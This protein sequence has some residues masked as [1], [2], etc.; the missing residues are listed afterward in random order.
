MKINTTKRNFLLKLLAC[1]VFLCTMI[2]AVLGTTSYATPTIAEETPKIYMLEGASVRYSDPVGIRFTAY[3]SDE[4]FTDGTLNEGVTVGMLVAKEGGTATAT[5]LTV[6]TSVAGVSNFSTKTTQDWK[7]AKSD[8]TGYQKYQVVLG[9][10]DGA[11]IPTTA[12][13]T[14]L[15]ARAYVTDSTGTEYAEVQTRSIARVANAELALN[16]LTEELE[17]DQISTLES[18]VTATTPND[19]QGHIALEN[20]NLVWTSAWQAVGYFVQFGDEVIHVADTN[21][22][23]RTETY[24]LALSEFKATTGT[25][26]MIAYG[27]GENQT[28][29][30]GYRAL[31]VIDVPGETV[32]GV[33]NGQRTQNGNPTENNYTGVADGPMNVQATTLSDGIVSVETRSDDGNNRMV[34]FGLALKE[35]LDLTHTGLEISFKVDAPNTEFGKDAAGLHFKI[36]GTSSTWAQ[37]NYDGTVG[38]V[39]V[40]ANAEEWTTLRVKSEELA[41]FYTEDSWQIVFCLK[42][43]GTATRYQWARIYIKEVKYYD[44]TSLATPANVAV[45]NNGTITW[46]AVDGATAG[47]TVMING[48]E[49]QAESNTYTISNFAA[50]VTVKVCA[51]GTDTN[52]VSD[53]SEEVTTAYFLSPNTL[54]DFNTTAATEAFVAGNPNI[55][56]SQIATAW[57]SGKPVVFDANVGE[58]GAVNINPQASQ[59]GGMKLFIFSVK[60]GKTLDLTNN[61]GVKVKFLVEWISANE[62]NKTYFTL[63]HATDNTHAGYTTEVTAESSVCVEITQD[64]NKTNFQTLTLTSADLIALGYSEKDT[65]TFGIWVPTAALNGGYSACT[66]LDDIS[67]YQAGES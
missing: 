6:D 13:E 18:Y 25:V 32:A 63:L 35:K 10:L 4:Y 59:I 9:G 40:T 3:V 30:A 21:V 66:W 49:Y 67:Y 8:V 46:D 51:N 61:A 34:V 65:L 27:D 52:A 36:V 57:R 47:Y 14:D 45:A 7:W 19:N 11:S 15:M 31:N 56:D 23:V 1:C 33:T 41:Q 54:I 16:V 39:D 48:N 64:G 20:G 2:A 12:N 53:W 44:M 29:I 60:L 5:D 26:K 17:A 62:K 28:R 38:S 55:T 58:G 43:S 42:H 22:D 37:T 50:D 24:S